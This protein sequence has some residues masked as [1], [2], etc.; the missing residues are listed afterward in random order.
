MFFTCILWSVVLS[1]RRKKMDDRHWLSLSKRVKYM[2]LH[3]RHRSSF[4]L[5]FFLL[6]VFICVCSPTQIGCVCFA[7][8]S[9]VFVC[10][11]ACECFCVGRLNE[12][13]ANLY[14]NLI[15]SVVLRL[16]RA[17]EQ[18]KK[19]NEQISPFLLRFFRQIFPLALY[20]RVFIEFLRESNLTE[21][22]MQSCSRETKKEKERLMKWTNKR[23]AIK[24]QARTT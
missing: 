22:I 1:F 19:A 5:L 2:R 11:F 14:I 10:C 12:F 3:T 20:I 6:R 13:I 23:Y 15:G 17:K 8:L 24:N 9:I 16:R 18:D 4:F 7:H 21:S